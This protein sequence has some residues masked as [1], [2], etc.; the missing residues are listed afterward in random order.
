[1]PDPCRTC[2][3]R[4]R[5]FAG[6]RCQSFALTGDASAADPACS[7]SPRHALVVDAR[8]RADAATPPSSL[9]LRR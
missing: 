2:D 4:T 3:E 7:L 9:R 5:D 1:M 6:C 8:T